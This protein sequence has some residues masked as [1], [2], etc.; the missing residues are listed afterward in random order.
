[1]FKV[2]FILCFRTEDIYWGISPL[3]R[4]GVENV[5]GEARPGNGIVFDLIFNT[6]PV[7]I[8]VVD[9]STQFHTRLSK[10]LNAGLRLG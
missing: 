4:S 10:F 8:T 1:M 9:V 6:E 7:R 3:L 5:L 2:F